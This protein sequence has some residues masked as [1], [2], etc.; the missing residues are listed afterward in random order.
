MKMNENYTWPY[1]MHIISKH[2]LGGI[3]TLTCVV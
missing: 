3:R 2:E 1:D